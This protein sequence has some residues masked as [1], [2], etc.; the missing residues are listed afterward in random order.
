MTLTET[1]TWFYLVKDFRF[2]VSDEV[3]MVILLHANVLRNFWQSSIDDGVEIKV[4][5]YRS[6]QGAQ[7]SEVL[8]VASPSSFNRFG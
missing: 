1:I 7:A 3:N 2:I 6:D 5:A 4:I 8:S